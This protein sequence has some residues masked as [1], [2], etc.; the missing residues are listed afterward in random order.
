[1]ISEWISGKLVGKVWT[2]YIWLRSGTNDG[3][4]CTR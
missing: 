4:L 2:R 3:L 1:V